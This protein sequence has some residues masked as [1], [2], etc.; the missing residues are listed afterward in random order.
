VAVTLQ[1]RLCLQ[2]LRWLRLLLL[3]L[4]RPSS[5][6]PLPLLLERQRPPLLVWQRNVP[7]SSIMDERVAHDDL[8]TV[9]EAQHDL[10]QSILV[11]L[12]VKQAVGGGDLTGDSCSAPS[13]QRY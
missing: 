9:A 5:H 3:P 1:L 12:K 11:Y 8:P 7:H 2:I 6:P 4:L 10:S 13:H